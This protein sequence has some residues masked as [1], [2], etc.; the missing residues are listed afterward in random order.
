ERVEALRQQMYA[1]AEN[2]QFETAARLRD[3]LR[4]L[5]AGE[6]VAAAAADGA[7]AGRA[8]AG[9]PKARKGRAPASQRRRR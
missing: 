9:R 6:P 1:A 3:E 4:R 2:L 8:G 5:Q 7:D